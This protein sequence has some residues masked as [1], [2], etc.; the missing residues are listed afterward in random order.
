MWTPQSIV[1]H[2]GHGGFERL[3]EA[4]HHVFGG[5]LCPARTNITSLGLAPRLNV[6]DDDQWV[7]Y[8]ESCQVVLC[9]RACNTVF[10][11]M[12]DRVWFDV[13]VTR[14]ERAAH[15]ERL[16]MDAF[17]DEYLEDSSSS[18]HVETD[19]HPLP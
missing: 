2:C 13:S 14:R 10:R 19:A 6:F 18:Y 11:A 4:N 15:I 9:M 16:N 1:F 8:K 12:Y 5:Y 7:A 3:G 17:I